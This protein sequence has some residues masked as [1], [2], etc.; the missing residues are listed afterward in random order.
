M[1][2]KKSTTKP[3]TAE[4]VPEVPVETVAPVESVEAPVTETATQKFVVVL[5]KLQGF[6]NDIKEMIS[7]VKLLQKEHA[8]LV[9]TTGKKPK[10][11]STGP[12]TLSGFAKPSLLSNE[13]CDFMGVAHG[14]SMARTEVTRMINEYIKTNNLQ[15]TEDKRTIIPDVK[16]KKIL[17][18]GADDKLTYFNL[19][20]FM[21][22]HFTKE[23]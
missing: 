11:V 16:L 9:K 17:N 21:K 23:A 19:Q 8:K 1:P 5:E 7:T 2:S 22:H 13:L 15:A 10:K 20:K 18:I 12:R 14:T 4:P 3:T 6:A